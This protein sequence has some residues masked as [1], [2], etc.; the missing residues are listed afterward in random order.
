M[1]PA[2]LAILMLAAT[3]A[4][5]QNGTM[6]KAKDLPPPPKAEQRPHSYER[7]GFTVEDP[8]FWLKD[9]GYPKID[10]EDVLSYLKAE[11][12]YFEAAMKPHGKLVDTL[13]EEMKGRVK[14]DESS[15]P[16]REGDWLYWWA[17]KPGAQYRTWYRK[18][19]A[20]GAEQ[21]MFD[22]V[23]EAEARNISSSAR[24]RS[25]P[26]AGSPP[27]SST[28]TARSAS[29]FASAT[30]PPAR[31]SR[32]SPKWASANRSGAAIR[33]ASSTTRSTTTGAA[34]GPATIASA[35]LPPRTRRC[36]R[37][38]RNLGFTV[39]ISKA[40]DESLIF[41]ST[42]DN[43]TNEVRFVSAKDPTQPLTL[44][45]PRKDKR[46]IRSTRATA[47]CGC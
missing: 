22:E 4:S 47:S 6:T 8:Y 17:Y 2:F 28:T 35:G 25:A 45:S 40:Q 27:P 39:G 32:R 5:A 16:V 41:I 23:A 18:P 44:M 33:R 34:T 15:V 37:R 21:V 3:A 42:G 14:E 31:I 10:D 30:S 29:I 36:T 7:H 26:T 46:N 13:F 9:Q 19:V 20:G 11:N 12:A 38:P 1:K 24:S 43:A